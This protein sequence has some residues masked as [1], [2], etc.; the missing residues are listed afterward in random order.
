MGFCREKFLA[1]FAKKN[2]SRLIKSAVCLYVC[3]PL[4][5]LEQLGR[6]S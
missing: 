6:F 4:I 3:P 5:T 2:E 1:Y